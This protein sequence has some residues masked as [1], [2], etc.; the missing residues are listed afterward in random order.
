[1]RQRAGA[2][3]NTGYSAKPGRPVTE[4]SRGVMNKSHS[5]ADFPL[6]PTALK[7]LRDLGSSDT[8]KW[9]YTV[10]AGRLSC[11]GLHENLHPSKRQLLE[12]MTAIVHFNKSG[13]KPKEK[14]VIAGLVCSQSQQ[15][16]VALA[17]LLIAVILHQKVRRNMSKWML[18]VL[19]KM[20][21]QRTSFINLCQL[22]KKQN[23][24]TK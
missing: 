24:A 3:A 2:C 10:C 14:S 11:L 23:K 15:S 21:D 13:Q 6:T 8:C 17:L 9:R 12:L 18:R 4:K 20:Y 16:Q 7:C 1:M 19:S 22:K 5:P